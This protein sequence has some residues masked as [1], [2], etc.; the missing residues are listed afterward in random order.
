MIRTDSDEELLRLWRRE[1]LRPASGWDFG[2]LEGR[3]TEEHPPWDFDDLCR[4][5]LRRARHVLDMGTGGGEQLLAFAADLPE[6]TVATEGWPPNLPVARGALEP[7]GI[8]VVFHDP[9]AT[10]AASQ[11]MPFD[12]GRFDLVLN[13]HEAFGAEELAR[14]LTPGGSFLTQQVGGDDAAEL[15]E[16][17]GHPG[18]YTQHRLA[19]R[20]EAVRAAGLEVTDSGEW[21]GT[22]R[23]QDV[24]ALV[25][26]LR[27]VPWDAPEDFTV[28]GY[29]GRLLPAAPRAPGPGLDRDRPQV[30]VPR[31]PAVRCCP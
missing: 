31:D 27:L 14:I 18:L 2:H 5:E 21:W 23:F 19:T 29:A 12:D 26:Y 7:H 10:D 13:R 30:L 8:P 15:H 20:L 1:E 4:R 25:G 16:W 28:D 6:D 11:R 22:Y 9:E 24:T 17:F 3:M